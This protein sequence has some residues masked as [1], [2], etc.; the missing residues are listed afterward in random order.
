MA[1]EDANNSSIFSVKTQWNCG[2]IHQHHSSL[3]SLY[4]LMPY[5]HSLD[6][7]ITV[8]LVKMML[9]ISTPCVVIHRRDLIQ[10]WISCLC[11]LRSFCGLHFTTLFIKYHIHVRKY[12][13]DG[14]IC[15]VWLIFLMKDSG[16]SVFIFLGGRV[17]FIPFT[18]PLLLS[19][20]RKTCNIL[21]F[22]YHPRYVFNS[23]RL[24]YPD[25]FCSY[26]G[27][28]LVR[29]SE[30]WSGWN[31]VWISI[32]AVFCIFRPMV[33]WRFVILDVYW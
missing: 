20:G 28:S 3:L 21:V 31:M 4:P 12:L 18:Q 14:M 1:I 6:H 24:P 15:V 25:S 8:G 5:S 10:T 17:S 19:L 27:L 29:V 9:F 32:K 2:G 30:A 22:I 23:T 33:G 16:L 11:Q 7:S 13:S 26:R